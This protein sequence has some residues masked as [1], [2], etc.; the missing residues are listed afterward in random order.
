MGWGAGGSR[1]AKRH[2][3]TET[4]IGR[5]EGRRVMERERG[6][7]AGGRVDGDFQVKGERLTETNRDRKGR[8]SF[9]ER[10]S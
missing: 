5:H 4:E 2:I 7:G 3:K 1:R 6:E 10:H 9:G 8:R